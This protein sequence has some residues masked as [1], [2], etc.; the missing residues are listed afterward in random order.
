MFSGF[1]TDLQTSVEARVLGKTVNERE[2]VGFCDRSGISEGYQYKDHIFDA[3][4]ICY[5]P[6]SPRESFELTWTK[7]CLIYA[8]FVLPQNNACSVA[9]NG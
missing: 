2:A 7:V 8:S 5:N 1:W 3:V 9:R 6:C 4:A